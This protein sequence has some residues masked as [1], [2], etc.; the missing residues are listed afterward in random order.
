MITHPTV[1]HDEW[2]KR[3]K[4]LLQKE[5]AFSLAREALAAE[6]RALP[7]EVI[8][9]PYAFDTKSGRR[10]LAELFDGRGQLVV[11]HFMYGPGWEEGCKSC[12]FWADSFANAAPHLAARD[13]TLCAISRAPLGEFETFRQRMGWSFPWHS[14]APGDF[15]FDFGVSFNDQQVESGAPYNYGSATAVGDEMPGLSVFAKSEDGRVYHTYST[16]G[17]GLDNIN[18]VYQLLDL[19]PK[20]RDEAALDWSMQWLRLRDEYE[21]AADKSADCCAG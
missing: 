12:S 8:S 16:Y 9:K 5:K 13:A 20:G 11:Y 3:R 19:T 2:L 7:W 4:R 17:R 15:N 14:S 18:T 10:S 6:R 1:S 21:L